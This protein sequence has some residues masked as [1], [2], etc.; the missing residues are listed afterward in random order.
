VLKGQEA[1]DRFDGAGCTHGVP[2]NGFKGAGDDLPSVRPESDVQRQTFR[3]VVRFCR[4]TVRVHIVDVVDS[5][6]PH[7]QSVFHGGEESL[8]FRVGMDDVIAIRP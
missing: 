5:A 1:A 3:F 7:F 8:S 2:Q 6:P 4:G